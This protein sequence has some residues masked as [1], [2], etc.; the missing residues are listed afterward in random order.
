[1]IFFPHFWLSSNV[2][3]F[4]SHL[5]PLFILFLFGSDLYFLNLFL[6]SLISLYLSFFLSLTH[7]RMM[8]LSLMIHYQLILWMISLRGSVQWRRFLDTWTQTL[9]DRTWTLFTQMHRHNSTYHGATM[10]TVQTNVSNTHIVSSSSELWCLIW[11]F[12]YEDTLPLVEDPYKHGCF[13][14]GDTQSWLCRP[15]SH[16]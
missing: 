9:G 14:A 16:G 8:C 6:C 10:P 3:Y 4:H 15:W 5:F 13:N 2:P 12:N 11:S 7:F 1:M